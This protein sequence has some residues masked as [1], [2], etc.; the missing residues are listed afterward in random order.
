MSHQQTPGE[1]LSVA[2]D[3]AD[4]E[5]VSP[6]RL[7]V[8]DRR[9]VESVLRTVGAL[10]VRPRE[11]CTVEEF[12]RFAEEFTSHC[13]EPDNPRRVESGVLPGTQ[14]VNPGTHAIPLHA[15]LAY[16]PFPPDYMFF[17]VVR[18]ADHGGET[19]LC[20]GV[21][22]WRDLE[23]ATRDYFAG[24]DL[25]YEIEPMHH[26]V[27]ATNLGLSTQTPVEAVAAALG[28]HAGITIGRV[29]TSKIGFTYRVPAVHRSD[30]RMAFS[31]N[32]LSWP[33]LRIGGRRPQE[34][35]VEAVRR[36]AAQ[37]TKVVRQRAGDIVCVNNRLVMHGRSRYSG[38]RT[39][40]VRMG[41]AREAA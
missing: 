33:T 29:S 11:Q 35:M 37:H 28:A 30:G 36:T 10:L 34:D 15:E 21:G 9:Q 26:R 14:S 7:G 39:V 8:L 18:P 38:T 22:L 16:T 4:L 41:P 40:L 17:H 12:E 13:V 5:S 3:T 27:I 25:E 32:V 1:R 20:D 19:I 23:S 31:N 24:N 2:P 6:D